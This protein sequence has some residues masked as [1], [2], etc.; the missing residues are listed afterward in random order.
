MHD[1]IN[2][3]AAS[4]ISLCRA[5]EWALFSRVSSMADQRR[6]HTPKRSSASL[7]Q[8]GVSPSPV[9]ALEREVL[10]EEGIGPQA[11]HPCMIFRGDGSIRPVTGE[12]TL[13]TWL[14]VGSTNGPRRG[15]MDPTN[16]RCRAGEVGDLNVHRG[17]KPRHVESEK[18][19][20]SGSSICPVHLA[21]TIVSFRPFLSRHSSI[22]VSQSQG[23]PPT[24][25]ALNSVPPLAEPGSRLPVT[26]NP[27]QL[28]PTP[29]IPST[30]PNKTS[31]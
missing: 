2:Q 5:C 3:N 7:L 1:A 27:V 16:M 10:D 26:L 28:L 12:R 8:I 19:L 15:S 20:C 11:V 14:L 24:R 6:A 22:F 17:C 4:Q 31:A 13:M 21:L 23:P 29:I 9:T 18:R 30:F 25:P